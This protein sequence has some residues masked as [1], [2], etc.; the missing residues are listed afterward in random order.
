MQPLKLI[1]HELLNN[2]ELTSIVHNDLKTVRKAIY[3]RRRKTLPEIPRSREDIFLQ[4][5][6]IKT[7]T[8]FINLY[9]IPEDESFVC[10]TSADNL[11]FMTTKCSDL[12]ADELCMKCN[13][14]EFILQKLHV[15]FEKAAHQAT[16]EIFEDLQLISCR[17]HL[18]QSWWRKAW[19]NE[20]PLVSR[21]R[22][23]W[24]VNFDNR[25]L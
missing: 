17:F 24:Q 16:S 4:L 23:A 10:I 20:V 21:N 11:Q 8:D 18:G 22:T 7:Q 6:S 12:F 3:D 5:H 9:I 25:P 1:R 2:T 15:D 19:S 13:E 14:T